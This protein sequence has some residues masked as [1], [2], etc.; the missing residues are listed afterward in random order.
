[1]LKKL[2]LLSSSEL[3]DGIPVFRTFSVKPFGFLITSSDQATTCQPKIRKQLVV[4][5][6]AGIR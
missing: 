4:S 3:L 1:M 6:L 2:R 5:P